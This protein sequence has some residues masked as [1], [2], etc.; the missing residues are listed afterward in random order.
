MDLTALMICTVLVVNLGPGVV[1]ILSTVLYERERR[2]T[3]V[4]VLRYTRPGA[5]QLLV[6]HDPMACD[7]R[8]FADPTIASLPDPVTGS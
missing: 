6:H 8:I 1:R 5:A 2:A 3:L 7:I 4:E